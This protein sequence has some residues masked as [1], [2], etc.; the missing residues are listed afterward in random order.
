MNAR[1]LVFD[2]THSYQKHE[3]D[4]L[5]WYDCSKICGSRLYCDK[6][7]E[8]KIKDIIRQNGISGIHFIDSGDYHYITKFMTDYIGE[9]F[10]LV[11]IDHHTDMQD[12]SLGDILSCGNWA[13]NVL[14]ENEYLKKLVLVGQQQKSLSRLLCLYPDKLV[15]ISYEELINKTAGSK[16]EAL[17]SQFPVYISIDKDVL[18]EKYAVTNWDQGE[19]SL[20]MLFD[21]LRVFIMN[22]DV[23][24]IDI[25]G[26][27]PEENNIPEFI[28][29]ERINT[30]S[31]E[32]LY[33]FLR[34]YMMND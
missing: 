17:E 6:E 32:E 15:G 9:P 27:L 23:I 16:I 20:C 8:K 24:G 30:E 33:N 5:L 31:D 28:R 25:C 19:M 11:L 12:G 1:N 29:A 22:Y 14:D 21:V 34:K 18:N 7:A 4:G 10:I 26:D 13:Q 3:E 2:F